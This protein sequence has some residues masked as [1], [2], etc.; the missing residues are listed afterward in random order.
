[1]HAVRLHTEVHNP[2]ARRRAL[3]LHGLGSDGP[4]TWRLAD[5]LAGAGHEVT[6]PD[7]RGHGR[8]PVTDH[9]GIDGYAADVA[10]LGE[11][12]DVVVGHSLGGGVLAVL[13]ARAGFAERGVLLDPALRLPSGPQRDE[14]RT[15]MVAEVGGTLSDVALAAAQPRWDAADVRRKV[16]AS[17]LVLPRTVAATFDHND[18]WD[19]LEHAEQWRCPVHLVAADPDHGALLP[20]DQ[21]AALTSRDGVTA[22][23]II[24]AGHSVHRDDPGAAVAAVLAQLR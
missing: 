19:V 11:G 13:C 1:M 14:L 12:W 5:A 3:V 15:Q 4:T 9:L 7:L 17:Q 6:V 2:A 21:V 24:G 18:P 23:T 22:T 8:S 10:L 20:P 16:L